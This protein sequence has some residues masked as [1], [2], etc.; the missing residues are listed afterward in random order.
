MSVTAIDAEF[1]GVGT[2]AGHPRNVLGLQ[3]VP[4]GTIRRMLMAAHRVELA[5][6]DAS[7]RAALAAKLQG[8]TVA[9]L[10]FE[11]STRTRSSFN[12][13]ASR[14]GA[15]VVELF[16]VGSSLSKGETLIDTARNVE[17]MG[18]E[19]IVVRAKNSGAAALIA[20]VVGCQV[21]NAGDGKHEHPT[22]GLLDIYTIGKEFGRIGSTTGGQGFDLSGLTVAIVGDVV[23]SRV[24]RSDIAGLVALG[25]KV[26]CVGP[27][28]FAPGSL[29]VLG[30]SVTND[31]DEVI[32]G[33]DAVIMLRIQFERHDEGKGD[34]KP[35]AGGSLP[36]VREYRELYAL[37]PERERAMKPGAIVMHPGPINRGIEI[38][39]SVADGARSRILAQVT[40]G[41]YVRTAVLS[42]E[43]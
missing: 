30:A 38:E 14:L 13:A 31:L 21:V 25:A 18:V 42:Q 8:K 6:A 27:P 34:G 20:G 17:A 16:G 33:V 7:A 9:N 15:H 32:G 12:L 23:S 19:S 10:F 22:Q 35:A 28:G 37:S 43:W 29:G 41:V 26:V 3:G 39:A 11:D 40:H 24:A 2:V 36:S 5:Q 4:A 1:T